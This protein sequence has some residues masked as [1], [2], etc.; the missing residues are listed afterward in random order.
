MTLK[1]SLKIMS[2]LLHLH[3]C[4]VFHICIGPNEKAVTEVHWDWYNTVTGVGTCTDTDTDT[5]TGT[6]IGPNE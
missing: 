6:D 2:L 4:L 1:I 5:D 3:E